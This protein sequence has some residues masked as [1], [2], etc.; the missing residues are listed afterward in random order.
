MS[1][2]TLARP[3]GVAL[4]LHVG[5]GTTIALFSWLSLGA[6]PPDPEPPLILTQ[7]R[8]HVIFDGGDSRPAPRRA[9]SSPA[10]APARRELRQPIVTPEPVRPDAPPVVVDDAFPG[11]P[12]IEGLPGNDDGGGGGGTGTF[13]P[14]GGDGP[15]GDDPVGADSGP[16]L[17]TGDM[18]PPHLIRKVS[19][20]YPNVARRAG[21]G[22]T[23]VLRAVIG[24]DG[25]VEEVTVVR[26]TSRLFV[27]AATE[28]VR[29]WRY[30]PAL[31]SG[32]PVRV[33][34][35]AVVEFKIR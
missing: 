35:E 2:T 22:G 12:T 1:D 29:Q 10:T 6:I 33:W 3:F 15:P 17:V 26:A 24:P 34:F 13:G 20:D 14:G 21:M 8:I 28:A 25:A 11:D 18:T 30:T 7:P 16:I 9:P 19:P 27:E 23:V 4:G 5:A 32:K 31:Q